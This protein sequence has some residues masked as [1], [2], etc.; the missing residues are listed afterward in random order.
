MVRRVVTTIL[1]QLIAVI[2]EHPRR[3][4]MDSR[5]DLAT[6]AGLLSGHGR[7]NRGALDPPVTD[8]MP[9]HD[10]AMAGRLKLVVFCRT[11]EPHL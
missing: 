7:L 2:T 11:G 4:A 10:L 9:R 6:A 8:E 5:R 1:G 3:S